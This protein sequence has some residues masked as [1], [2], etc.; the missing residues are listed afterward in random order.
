MNLIGTRRLDTERCIL[1][2]IKPDDYEMMY[3]NWAKYDEVCRYYPFHP[4]QNLD[5]YRE[6]VNR[7]VSNY[8]S[9]DY[10]HWVIELKKSGQLIGTINLGNVE[11][12]CLMADTCYMLS[13]RYW[14]MGIMTEV[15]RCVLEYAFCDIGF[16]RIQAEVF[17]GN[18]ASVRVLEKCGMKYEGTA[19]QKYLKD[20]R[21]IDAAQ[22]SIIRKD[23]FNT[24]CKSS[25]DNRQR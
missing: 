17:Y 2:C 5:A 8:T 11:E 1:R 9:N 4:V 3:E 15:L 14:G 13:P 10:F 18:D 22:Y 6:K 23:Y 21:F 25:D 12:S 7:W 20:D 24:N 19:R 16:N